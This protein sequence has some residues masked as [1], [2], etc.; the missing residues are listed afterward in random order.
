MSE[1]GEAGSEAAPDPRR[2]GSAAEFVARLRVLKDRSGLTCR[3]LSARAE[4]LGHALPRSTIA[5]MLSR[6]A[7]PSRGALTA[8]VL[9]CGVPVGELD[10]WTTARDRLAGRAGDG[11]A[12]PPGGVRDDHAD[13]AEP[14]AADADPGDGADGRDGPWAAWWRG[15]VTLVALAG[16][17]VAGTSVVAFVRG[18]DRDR[19]VVAPEPGDVR[20]RAMHSGLC[21][22]ERGGGNRS[23]F[24]Y[25]ASCADA[26]LPRYSL[27]PLDGG[28]WRLVTR[29]PGF[30]VGCSAVDASPDDPQRRAPLV[31]GECGG[32]E[33]RAAFRIERY[34]TD[35]VRGYRIRAAH[36]GLCLTP[37]GGT[38]EWAEIVQSPCTPDAKQQLFS[39]DRL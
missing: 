33:G 30:G 15:A 32:R 35:P 11:A 26:P 37:R 14:G 27:T 23:G 21:L 13:A 20:I 6:A 31:N 36:S 22:R 28:L 18:D 10:R 3:E 38:E 9:A 24:V 29:Y 34:G 1:Q 4:A 39:F 19:H 25:Q 2:A 16:L 12:A 17:V 8:Y 5:D 7:L